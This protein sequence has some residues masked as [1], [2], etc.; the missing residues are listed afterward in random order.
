MVCHKEAAFTT[1]LG[2]ETAIEVI[3]G[4][5]KYLSTCRNCFHRPPIIKCV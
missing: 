1:R 5:D 4:T 2:V 3:G